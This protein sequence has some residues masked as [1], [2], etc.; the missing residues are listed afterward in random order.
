MTALPPNS[1]TTIPL[2]LLGGSF[3]VRIQSTGPSPVQLVVESAVYR[4]GGGVIWSAGSNSLAT[5]VVP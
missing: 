2:A 3:G 5:P 4:S 1:R